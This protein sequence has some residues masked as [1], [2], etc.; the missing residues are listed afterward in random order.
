MQPGN[1]NGSFFGSTSL[2]HRSNPNDDP[3]QPLRAMADRVGKEVESFAE[4]VDQWHSQEKGQDAKKQYHATLRMVDQFKGLADSTVKELREQG[5]AEN[6]GE[7]RKSIQRRIRTMIEEE[8]P[9]AGDFLQS[10]QSVAS[11]VEGNSPYSSRVQE[12][13]QWESE[14][15][16]WDLVHLII[17]FYHPEPGFDREADR[18]S[19]ISKS[20]EPIHQYTPKSELWNCFLLVDDQ[21]K[22]KELVLRWLERTAMNTESDIQSIVEQLGTESGKD[23]HTWTSGWLDTRARIKQAKRL[24]GTE[25]PLSSEGWS[26]RTNDRSQELITQLDPDA[27]ARQKRALEKSDEDYER[28]LWMVCYEMLRRGTP[29]KEVS[30]WCRDRSEAWRGISMGAADESRPEGA[31]S[32]AGESVGY[33]FRRMCFLAARGARSHFEGAVYGLL[34]GDYKAVQR[35]CR[36]WDDH[37]YAHYNALLL[38]RFDDYLLN[39]HSR[40]LPQNLTHKF[41]FQD[42]VANV[43]DWETSPTFIVNLLKQQKATAALSLLPMKLIQGSLI[44]RTMEDLIFKVGVAIAMLQ[45]KDT[46][47]T[48]LVLEPEVQQI[49]YDLK[50]SIPVESRKW[51]A[52]KH[53]QALAS[54]TH[55]LRVLVHI[56]IVLQKGLDLFN[57]EDYA[58]RTAFDNIIV[59]YIELLRLTKRFQLIPLYA[60]QLHPE[61]IYHCLSRVVSDIKNPDE[62]K[63]FVGLMEYYGIDASIVIKDNWLTISNY[64]DTLKIPD[65]ETLG[66]LETPSEDVTAHSYLWPGKRVK[67]EFDG[68]DINETDEVMLSSLR[69]HLHLDKWVDDSFTVLHSGLMSL[70]RK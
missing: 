38:S 56:L 32:L 63:N 67:P 48:S 26:L 62:Q 47:L 4:R 25:G 60:A 3:L 16:T 7:L 21:A 11:S 44:G 24:R 43:G 27:P 10:A 50:E 68:F 49:Q 13:R 52:K 37:L 45:E 40:R 19:K 69:W 14:A 12:L 17:S 35:V 29:W 70:L 54:D 28:A 64:I 58:R 23:T 34:S 22:E 2:A 20:Y 1:H 59:T 66:L 53:H 46:R 30:E 5:D 33:I 55:A 18:R 39:H 6:R 9:L 51:T 36:S 61:R 65:I 57:T 15:A 42:A 8:A 41:I 31:P